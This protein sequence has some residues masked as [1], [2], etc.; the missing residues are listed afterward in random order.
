MGAGFVTDLF[1]GA[2]HRRPD[3]VDVE[4]AHVDPQTDPSV[5]LPTEHGDG[6]VGGR[7]QSAWRRLP[8]RVTIKKEYDRCETD[9]DDPKR[10]KHEERRKSRKNE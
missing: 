10:G 9:Q 6:A 3:D 1:E 4:G 5:I 8:T 7:D 2:T